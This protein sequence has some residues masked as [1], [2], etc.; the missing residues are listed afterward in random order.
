MSAPRQ[1]AEGAHLFLRSPDY[2]SQAFQKNGESIGGFS[3][4][5]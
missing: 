2:F 1:L 5:P 3:G 4:D